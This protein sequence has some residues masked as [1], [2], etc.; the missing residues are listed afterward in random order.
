MQGSSRPE[1]SSGS[2]WI[3]QLS[4]LSVSG[5]LGLFDFDGA[6]ELL[7]TTP[8]HVR[9]LWQERRIGG[10]KIGRKVR[11]TAQDLIAF[12]ESNHTEAL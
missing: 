5:P 10:C 9:R 3:A 12:V 6:A 7:R 11:F 1:E 8:R 4:G 2:E